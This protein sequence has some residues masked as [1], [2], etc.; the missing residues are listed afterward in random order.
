MFVGLANHAG[1]AAG[2]ATTGL[3]VDVGVHR[4]Q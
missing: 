2:Q 1:P 4:T 3:G